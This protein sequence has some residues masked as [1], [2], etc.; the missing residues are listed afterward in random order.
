MSERNFR[1][2]S[3]KHNRIH[4]SNNPPP[5]KDSEKNPSGPLRDKIANIRKESEQEWK[6]RIE[7]LTTQV[8]GDIEKRI[9]EEA[10]NLKRTSFIF[11]YDHVNESDDYYALWR[12][13]EY[14]VTSVMESV[15]GMSISREMIIT[16]LR[17]K[18]EEAGLKVSI[19]M[20]ENDAGYGNK[21]SE[22]KIS[23]D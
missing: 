21:L 4:S 16:E 1:V 19:K 17:A 13:Y 11:D 2:N 7:S 6:D 15:N 3:P 18:L 12:L 23:W 9:L 20:N 8:F 14:N 5:K 22:M 10:K